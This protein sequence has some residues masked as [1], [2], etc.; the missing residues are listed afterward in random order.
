VPAL[1]PLVIAQLAIVAHAPIDT[2][3]GVNFHA[4]ALPDTVYVG[5]QVT[6]QVG[7]F[8]DDELR[9]RLR[10]NPEFVP[11]DPR[12]MLTYELPAPSGAP[13]VRRVGTHQY[14]VHVFQRA[15]FPLEP[16]RYVIPPAQLAYAL[17]LSQSFFSRE[18]T[19]TIAAES[20]TVVALPPPAAGRPGDFGGAVGELRVASRFDS[21][22]IRV[23]DPVLLTIVVEGRGNVKL[24]PRP[25]LTVAWGTAVAADER[26]TVDT[27]TA[28]VRGTKEFDWIVTPHDTGTLVLAPVRYPYFDPVA[29]RYALALSAP[30]ALRVSPG[31]LAASDTATVSL[32]APL[33]IRSDFRGS[34]PAPSYMTPGFAVLAVVAPL[35]ALAFGV[36]RRRRRQSPPRPGARLRALARARLPADATAVRRAFVAAL[37]ERFTLAPETLSSAGGLARSLRRE[38]VTEATG[39]RAEQI[40]ARLDQGAYGGGTSTERLASSAYAAYQ[41]VVAE[42]RQ[43]L[44]ASGS[45]APRET[46][47]RRGPSGGA[48]GV[49]VLAATI[50][51]MLAAVGA[52]SADPGTDQAAAQEFRE[53][54]VAYAARDFRAAADRF[55]GAARLAPRAPDAWANAGTAAWALADTADAVVGWQRAVRLEPLAPDMRERLGLVRAPQDGR[56]AAPPRVGAPL[57]A[58]LALACW[59]VACLVWAVRAWGRRALPRLATAA[60]LGAVLLALLAIALDEGAAARGL[61]V[62]AG[63]TPL[64]VS[65][66]LGAEHRAMLDAGDVARVDG[67]DGGWVRIELD[68][69]REGWVESDRLT[70]IARDR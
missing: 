43:P 5:Q 26:V 27:T 41:A 53:G 20:L 57:V 22:A 23:G 47:R 55:V 45:P 17:P 44:A 3:S 29:D 46:P 28:D 58:D 66:A 59:L 67:H 69:D 54:V 36:G 24:L 13:A 39:R 14:E 2:T 60:A 48:A 31:A 19:H 61:A 49:L 25:A 30:A 40:L 37:A 7:V 35:P 8:L 34:L 33:A 63:G 51:A 4:M 42:A 52:A 50:G 12:A 62:V 9:M 56:L 11:P 32:P 21:H 1:L 38:G 65:P 16:G 10:R 18:E 64:L 68:G 70:S 6:Y 15:M